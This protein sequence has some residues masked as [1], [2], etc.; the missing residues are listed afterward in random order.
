MLEF[1]GYINNKSHRGQQ[2]NQPNEFMQLS[3]E[4]GTRLDE[5][6]LKDS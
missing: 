2:N 1:T 4:T 5:K 6:E 3:G